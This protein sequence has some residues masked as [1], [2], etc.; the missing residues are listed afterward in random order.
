MNTPDWRERELKKDDLQQAGRL[1]GGFLLLGIGVW[2]GARLFAG[3]A[4]LIDDT[5]YY[6]NIFT[7]V[8]SVILTIGVLNYL[9]E[10]R[11]DKRREREY[12][13]RLIR[14][15]NSLD[16]ATAIK[17]IR[18][19][20]EHR[21]L[22]GEN[23]ALQ[24]A[25]LQQ[26]NLSRASLGGANL[27]G[28][29]LWEVNLSRAYLQQA[30]LSGA[31]LRGGTNLSGASL[32]ETNLSGADLGGANLSGANLW[33]ANLSGASLVRANLSGAH[34]GEANLSGTGLLLANLSAADLR[35]AN[36]SGAFLGGANLSGSNL[37]A[38]NLE[39]A[40]IE[41]SAEFDVFGK[42]RRT[43]FDEH[44]TLPDGTN[45]TPDV[46]WSKFGVFTDWDEYDVWR[47]SQQAQSG[48]DES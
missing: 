12:K 35:W 43:L 33:E 3:D 9:A 7:E 37:E 6:T 2:I 4:P 26:A 27:S 38:V 13:A 16:N 1:S 19:L 21:W 14:E 46:D 18:E 36:L 5:G 45:W 23:G 32:W 20:D 34:L 30:D 15:A 41:M 31:H 29:N 40:Y 11:E 28:A 17:A 39:H 44:T 22:R 8:L 10:R 42:P 24:R 47:K 48:G 25:Y